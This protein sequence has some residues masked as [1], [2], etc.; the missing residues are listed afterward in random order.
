M[1]D[2]VDNG[3]MT[4]V[5]TGC[6]NEDIVKDD[7]NNSIGLEIVND[8]DNRLQYSNIVAN[9]LDIESGNIVNGNR[10]DIGEEDIVCDNACLSM[11]GDIVN[12][13]YGVLDIVNIVN[14]IM[15]VT[16]STEDEE[17]LVSEEEVR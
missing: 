15:I 17:E 3:M 16:E 6:S 7:L 13:E 10:S 4:I 1:V 5:D 14:D 11:K 9:E 8:N 2:I 12:N